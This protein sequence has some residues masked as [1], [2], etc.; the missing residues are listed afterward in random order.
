MTIPYP[1][2]RHTAV[3]HRLAAAPPGVRWDRIS[4]SLTLGRVDVVTEH[5]VTLPTRAGP[6]LTLALMFE[7]DG[8][9][10]LGDRVLCPFLGGC[11]YL[12]WAAENF[13]AEDYIPAGTRFR[14]AVLRFRSEFNR[15]LESV[16]TAPDAGVAVFRHHERAAW[17]ARTTL[18]AEMAEYGRR[19]FE[20]DIDD[21]PVALLEIES[22]ALRALHQ[23]VGRLLT[24]ELSEPLPNRAGS[25]P[26][27][28]RRRLLAARHHIETH[29]CERLSLADIRCAAAI[30]ERTLM[31]GFRALF[32][33]SPY[34]YLVRCRL[35]EAA[36]LLRT[37]DL[38]VGEI[39][40][41]CGFSHR[42]HLSRHFRR[43]YGLSPTAL[44]DS[45]Q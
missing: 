17:V 42:S 44:R 8:Q 32:G 18:T 37:T 40:L 41:R 23:F 34:A 3:T 15:L 39:S 25:L 1:F 20:F 13:R 28:I 14:V 30:G 31:V 11:V 26:G 5:D 12:S 2:S 33:E 21:N 19:L 22:L 4:E 35:E 45:S 27:R 24:P 29:A 38:S 43:H 36:R 7:G 6:H 10:L 9:C 16:Q